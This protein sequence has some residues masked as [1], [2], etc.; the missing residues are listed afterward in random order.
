LVLT[1]S[2]VIS[3]S[4]TEAKGHIIATVKNSEG[5]K[6]TPANAVLS[7]VQQVWSAKVDWDVNFESPNVSFVE[8]APTS[9]TGVSVT[10]PPTKFQRLTKVIEH[11]T[12]SGGKGKLI[13]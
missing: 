5:L 12:T 2:Q 3:S 11:K 8:G 10:S 9:G 4:P 1:L 7:L 6:T 13:T